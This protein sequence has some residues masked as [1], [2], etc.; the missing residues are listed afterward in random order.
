MSD[1]QPLADLVDRLGRIMHGLQFA[2][3]LNPAQ[4]EALRYFVRANRYSKT[5]KALANFLGTTKGTASQTLIS[6]ESK[7]YI[8][9]TRCAADRRSVE[10]ELTH[11][12]RELMG[13]DPLD[14]IADAAA[15]ISPA[16]SAVLV[17]AIGRMVKSVCRAQALNEFGC[18]ADCIHNCP[19]GTGDTA[20]AGCWCALTSEFLAPDETARICINFE[21][22]A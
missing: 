12:G 8:R 11:E 18:C 5:P 1:R 22:V 10:I 4:W 9:R 3:G 6:L 15:E 2:S 19:E 7:G 13:N 20:V 17:A 21:M 14:Q 16:E